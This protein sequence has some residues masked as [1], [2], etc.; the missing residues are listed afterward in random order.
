MSTKR[1]E[2]AMEA[3][4][5]DSLTPI[6]ILRRLESL[7]RKVIEAAK[8]WRRAQGEV[9]GTQP[10]VVRVWDELRRMTDALIDFESSQYLPPSG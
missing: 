4:T 6:E 1:K 5:P 7:E 10:Q 8:A 3:E 9:D 2:E